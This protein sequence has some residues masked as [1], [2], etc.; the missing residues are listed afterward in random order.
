MSHNPSRGLAGV[1]APVGLVSELFRIVA[2]L[3]WT[4]CRDNLIQFFLMVELFNTHA[5]VKSTEAR[6]KYG[7]YKGQVKLYLQSINEIKETNSEEEAVRFMEAA[8]DQMKVVMEHLGLDPEK[9]SRIKQHWNQ[10]EVDKAKFKQLS[11]PT[12]TTTTPT[13]AGPPIR[14]DV[15]ICDG[16]QELKIV[17]TRNLGKL[18]QI[19]IMDSPEA[20]QRQAMDSIYLMSPDSEYEARTRWAPIDYYDKKTVKQ[21]AEEMKDPRT[22]IRYISRKTRFVLVSAYDAE[23]KS[24]VEKIFDLDQPPKQLLEVLKLCELSNVASSTALKSVK[25]KGKGK[26]KERAHEY[27]Q[28]NDIDESGVVKWKFDTEAAFKTLGPRSCLHLF[29]SD[30]F[31][32]SEPALKETK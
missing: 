19:K 3:R 17:K 9:D 20:I 2:K 29:S 21:C 1:D 26:G 30:P 14:L 11:S 22:Q 4:R 18:G 6:K 23:K 27:T 5:N 16:S 13:K 15:M 28:H 7:S 10:A 12:S 8:R 32:H 31:F 24:R 25:G